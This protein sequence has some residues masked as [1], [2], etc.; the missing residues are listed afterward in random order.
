MNQQT[1]GAL[2]GVRRLTQS[3]YE[4]DERVPDLSYLM[5]LDAA[6]VDVVYLMRGHREARP[7]ANHIS[8]AADQL[9]EA[10]RLT[11]E[12]GTDLEGNP[13]PLDLRVRMFQLVVSSLCVNT[14]GGNLDLLRDKLSAFSHAQR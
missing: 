4:T 3:L 10:F 13:L 12:H 9:I 1:F 6:G 11:E 14:T 8:I 2:G 5:G 7:D